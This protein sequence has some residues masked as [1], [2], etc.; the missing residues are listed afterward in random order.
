M[1]LRLH[2]KWPSVIDGVE[3]HQGREEGPIRLG[4][5]LPAEVASFGENTFPAVESVEELGNG[6]VVSVLRSGE[7]RLVDAVIDGLVEFVQRPVH[8]LAPVFGAE[9]HPDRQSVV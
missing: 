9:I 6:L 2:L 7:A 4:N 1:R 3:A 8:F 5:A